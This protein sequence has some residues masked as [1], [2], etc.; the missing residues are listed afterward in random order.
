[1]LKEDLSLLISS[2]G[3]FSD[4]WEGQITM[5]D[6]HWKEKNIDTY[7]VTD[8][9]PENKSF[10]NV[11]ILTAGE[12]TEITERFSFFLKECKTEY[13]FI[14]LDD[15]YLIKDVSNKRIKYLIDVMKE[16]NLDYLRIFRLPSDG[17]LLSDT[18][19]IYDI[20]FR[21]DK[22]KYYVN[23][24]PGIWKKDFLA[25]TLKEKLNAWQYEVSLTPLAIEL[26]AKC[27]VDRADDYVL[28]DVVRKGKI[29]HKANK[30]FKENPGIYTGN[31]PL[32]SYFF[33]L[34]LFIYALC[35]KILPRKLIRGIKPF[36][37]KL[38]FKF[39]S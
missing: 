10:Q 17:K 9:N 25:K 35:Q 24:Y 29:L 37:R 36:L 20:P 38:G 5:L 11:K 3:A 33:E 26:N 7:I 8:T 22:S 18:D 4:L 28:L 16:K 30:Y 12:G 14:T 15:Y 1:M 39:Y 21:E 13:V 19:E 23:L 27:A 32:I 34:K 2:C 31:R 6:R